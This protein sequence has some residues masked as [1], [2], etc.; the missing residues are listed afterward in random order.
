MNARLA[1]F[2]VI[3]IGTAVW[4]CLTYKLQV[5]D[6]LK[7]TTIRCAASL[8]LTGLV[9]YKKACGVQY[10]KS[11]KNFQN[12]DDISFF[13]IINDVL[14]PT[15]KTI[16]IIE[17]GAN[18]GQFSEAELST[19]H[20][21]PYVVHSLEPII[22]L[23]DLLKNRSMTFK[24]QQNDKHFHYNI[25]ISDHSGWLPIYSTKEPIEGA[26]LGKGSRWNFVKIADVAV[27]TLPNFIK[28]YHIKTP[29]SFIKIDVE[30]LSQKLFWVWI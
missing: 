14:I 20:E 16:I 25:G 17:F 24:K 22:A 11:R 15:D 12:K 21:L 27:I 2:L 26:T 18:M 28:T 1:L 8:N 19:S 9:V 4:L 23:F 29:I 13:S 5:F 30:D 3:L 7:N 6:F 10:W